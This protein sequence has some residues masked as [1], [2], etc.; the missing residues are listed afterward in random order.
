MTCS[1]SLCP[2]QYAL[3]AYL[4]GSIPFGWLMGRIFFRRDIRSGGSGNVGATN[5]LRQF[6]TTAG[7]IVLLLDLA[8]GFTAAWLA[9]WFFPVGSV[10]I[11]VLG[12]LAILG[13]VFP[14]WLDFKGGKG[15]ATAAGVFIAL[16]PYPVLAALIVFI[17]I[18]AI[19]RYVSLGSMCAAV[20]LL[21]SLVL[22]QYLRGRFDYSMLVFTALVVIMIFVK[23]RQNIKR[24]LAGN[25]NKIRFSKKGTV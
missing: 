10:W 17:L 21:A 7:V 1:T 12:A 20:V 23:H 13:H 6:G 9:T 22:Q 2:F 14:I 19:S 5:A 16:T 25:E 18:T 15:V 24:L 11:P 8:K 3:L 4:I